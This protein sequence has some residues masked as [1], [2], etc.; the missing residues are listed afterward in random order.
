MRT[1][2]ENGCVEA[3]SLKTFRSAVG[4]VIEEDQVEGR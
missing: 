3:F 2:L 4:A 1:G